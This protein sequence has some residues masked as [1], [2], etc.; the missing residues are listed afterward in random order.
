MVA[1]AGL[2]EAAAE[3]VILAVWDT[4]LRVAVSAAVWLVVTVPAVAVK[5]VA[6]EPAGTVREAAGTGN[7]AALLDNDTTMPPAGAV[8]LRVTV[9]VVAL[10]EYSVAG[11][12][13]S[14]LRVGGEVGLEDSSRLRVAVCGI[15]AGTA[16]EA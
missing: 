12:H 7:R 6:V 1:E 13:A 3:S 2:G 9:Q 10:P 14:E 4:P 8:L 15:P 5:V 16:A 11:L